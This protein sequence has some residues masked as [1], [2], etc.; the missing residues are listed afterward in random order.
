MQNM[1]MNTSYVAPAEAAVKFFKTQDATAFQH[2]NEA[3]DAINNL[4]DTTNTLTTGIANKVMDFF[5][6]PDYQQALVA[7]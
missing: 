2:L 1:G 6:D 7:G 3:E 4:P 5:G